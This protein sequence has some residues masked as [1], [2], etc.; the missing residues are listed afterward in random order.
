MSERDNEQDAG[1]GGE[2]EPEALLFQHDLA[3]G[4]VDQQGLAWGNSIGGIERVPFGG[5]GWWES[6]GPAPLHVLGEQI[7]QGIGPNSGQV[8]DIAIDP[9]GDR[10]T[11]INGFRQVGWQQR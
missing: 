7:F 1:S 5:Q 10:R 4:G 3:A 11:I 9:S 6:I 2:L 8:L